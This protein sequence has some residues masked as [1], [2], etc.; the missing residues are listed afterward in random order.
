MSVLWKWIDGKDFTEEGKIRFFLIFN[1]ILFSL[2]GLLAWL[3]V[4][5]FVLNTLIWAIC[6]T[7]YPGFF[8]GF[9]GGYL[10]LCRN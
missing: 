9:I 7:G 2:L 6:F 8:V 1:C 10:Y 3:I 5:R 4:S